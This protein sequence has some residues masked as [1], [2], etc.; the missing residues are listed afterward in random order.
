MARFSETAIKNVLNAIL[1]KLNFL[2]KIHLGEDL[3]STSLMCMVFLLCR[4]VLLFISEFCEK[5]LDN[6]FKIWLNQYHFHLNPLWKLGR[7]LRK[8]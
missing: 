8:L 6:L 5:Y 2:E 1:L 7:T 4:S 3:Y